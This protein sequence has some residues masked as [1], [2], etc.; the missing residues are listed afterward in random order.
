MT[1][2]R[3]SWSKIINNFHFSCLLYTKE[4]EKPNYVTRKA[5]NNKVAAT[6]RIVKATRKAAALSV[7]KSCRKHQIITFSEVNSQ[8]R[9]VSWANKKF[10]QHK[11]Y[12][13][14]EDG[15]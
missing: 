9:T 3:S 4:N 6:L 5:D 12:T 8:V 11:Y 13:T 15:Y 14:F 7:K 2:R 10:A 1:S